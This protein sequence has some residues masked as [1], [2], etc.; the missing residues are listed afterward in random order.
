MRD[1]SALNLRS[2][3]SAA[4]DANHRLHR[5]RHGAPPRRGPPHPHPRPCA[6]R[7][8]R[9]QPA[10]EADRACD[11]QCLRVPA[12]LRITSSSTIT[13]VPYHCVFTES[14]GRRRFA[15]FIGAPPPPSP[16]TGDPRTK[17]RLRW[18][19]SSC[20]LLRLHLH[21]SHNEDQRKMA[22]RRENT[23]K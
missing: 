2:A 18:R 8:F 7:G 20:H 5:R 3:A 22:E 12:P 4:L 10:M 14:W 13:T 1:A 15:L 16:L 21:A 23:L 9:H 19:P 6:Q 11:V 17:V